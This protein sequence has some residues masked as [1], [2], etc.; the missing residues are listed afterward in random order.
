MRVYRIDNGLSLR[1]SHQTPEGYRYCEGFAAKAG[2]LVYR[3][4]DGS[5]VRELVDEE[6]L[7]DPESQASLALKPVTLHHPEQDVGPENIGELGV[8]LV[9][10]QVITMAGGYVKVVLTV[11][12]ADALEAIEKGITELSPGYYCEVIPTPGVHPKHGA[13]DAIQRG[14]RY[15][16]L[17]IVDKARGGPDIHLRA[18]SAI[19]VVSEEPTPTKSKSMNLQFLLLLAALGVKTQGRKDAEGEA[20]ASEGV[21]A[22]E[23]MKAENAMLKNENAALKAKM[24]QMEQDKA[25]MAKKAE[26]MTPMEPAAAMDQLME[27]PGDGVVTLDAKKDHREAMTAA[28]RERHRLEQL[29]TSARLDAD[30]LKLSSADLRKAVALALVPNARKDGSADYYAGLLAARADAADDSQRSTDGADPYQAIG[31]QFEQ[32]RQERTDSARGSRSRADAD[33]PETYPVFDPFKA[34]NSNR[35]SDSNRNR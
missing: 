2:V 23:A 24:L 3:R 12:R 29:A 35:P 17:A 22:I 4:A 15:N 19:Q 7:S 6:T 1:P 27:G 13:Y 11:T 9:G 21:A 14:R 30:A 20:M 8:G 33:D 34:R 31:D 10:P 32:H 16:H 25:D 18:D 28:V 5:V 26:G